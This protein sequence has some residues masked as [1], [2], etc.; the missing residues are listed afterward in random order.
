MVLITDLSK[1]P[2][3]YEFKWSDLKQTGWGDK[4]KFDPKS[5]VGLNWTS[6][7]AV[8]WDFTIDDVAFLE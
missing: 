6:K 7:D 2:K 8:A 3:T 1:E 4:V 5:V